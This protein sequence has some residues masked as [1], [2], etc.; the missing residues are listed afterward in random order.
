MLSFLVAAL[1]KANKFSYSLKQ[2]QSLFLPL[3]LLLSNVMKRKLILW[4]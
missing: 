1:T 4:V 2:F 3:A